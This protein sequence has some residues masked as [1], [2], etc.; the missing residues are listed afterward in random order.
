MSLETLKDRVQSYYDLQRLRIAIENR[1]RAIYYRELGEQVSK[2]EGETRFKQYI[3]AISHKSL[4]G[5]LYTTLEQHEKE[6]RESIEEEVRMH[7]LWVGWLEKIKG[8]GYLHSA[9]LISEIDIREADTIS[10]L[11]KYA[12]FAPGFDRPKSGEK[13]PY[14]K[15]LKRT[16]Y[17]IMRRFIMLKTQPYERVYR[18]A[19]QYYQNREDLKNAPKIRLERMAMRK[20]IKLFLS[21]LYPAPRK[22]T[23]QE[24][25]RKPINESEPERSRNPRRSSESQQREGNHCQ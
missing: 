5:R 14:N 25:V 13:L 4:L 12:G 6:L 19:K 24:K 16:C 20:G 3:H 2:E 9:V 15:F 1:L 17:L 23:S 8:V 21:H 7:P 18:E 11:W 10:S 22:T